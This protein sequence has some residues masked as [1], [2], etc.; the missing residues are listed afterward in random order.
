MHST[1]RELPVKSQPVRH[2]V[3]V[4]SDKPPCTI[5][6]DNPHEAETFIAIMEEIG[7][8]KRV[9]GPVVVLT[10]PADAPPLPGKGRGYPAW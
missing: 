6:T 2:V 5:P 8:Q 7:W 1:I 3:L 9:Q 10:E 4:T